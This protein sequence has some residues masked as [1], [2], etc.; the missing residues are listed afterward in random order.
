MLRALRIAVSVVSGLCCLL[1]IVLWVRSYWWTDYV[2]APSR[3]LENNFG[4]SDQ[5]WIRIASFRGNKARI[6]WEVRH[7]SI[8]ERIESDK[9]FIASGGT[10]TPRENR[11]RFE[12]RTAI[13]Q[14]PHW[15]LVLI[16]VVCAFSPWVFRRFSLRTLFLTTTAIALLLG[17]IVYATR[18]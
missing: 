5:G 15:F 10:I 14:F 17:R 4:L 13:I 6:R 2:Y 1:V 12:P 7:E 18:G 9:K 16:F 8:A 3:A 11:F